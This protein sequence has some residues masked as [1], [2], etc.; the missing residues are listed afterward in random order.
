MHLVPP[1][2]KMHLATALWKTGLVSAVRIGCL[3]TVTSHLRM[4]A[5]L[6]RKMRL[7]LGQK[8]RQ[9]QIFCSSERAKG[10][11]HYDVSMMRRGHYSRRSAGL[12]EFV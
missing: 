10:N 11:C 2:W 7:H 1:L 5:D 9:V 8:L 4:I 3:M 12:G 6:R